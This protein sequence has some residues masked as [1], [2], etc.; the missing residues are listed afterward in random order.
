MLL[1]LTGYQMQRQLLEQRGGLVVRQVAGR[2][3]PM[4]HIEILISDS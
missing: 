2:Y 1:C 4:V 3:S